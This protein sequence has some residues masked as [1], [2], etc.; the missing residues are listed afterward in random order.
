MFPNRRRLS[1]LL[2]I[3]LFGSLWVAPVAAQRQPVGVGVASTHLDPE[4]RY[5]EDSELIGTVSLWDSTDDG[6]LDTKIIW[7][8]APDTEYTAT[9]ADPTSLEAG[10]ENNAFVASVPHD[11]PPLTG[12]IPTTPTAPD[13]PITRSLRPGHMC[14]AA[15]ADLTVR[16]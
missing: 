12:R 16:L 6:I 14:C 10:G 5:T 1:V 2:S 15:I 8:E 13:F 7:I 11:I 9:N 4:Y 3:A